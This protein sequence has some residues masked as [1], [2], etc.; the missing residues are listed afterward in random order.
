[1]NAPTYSTQTGYHTQ[2]VEDLFRYAAQ[3]FEHARLPFRHTK[4][5]KLIRSELRVG[6]VDVRR[7]IDAW[8]DRADHAATWEGFELFAVGCYADPTGAHAA[9]N[10]DNVAK[11]VSAR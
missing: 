2:T 10:I 7:I 4:M 1:M 5:S 9:K 8:V 11:R 3:Q 6:G